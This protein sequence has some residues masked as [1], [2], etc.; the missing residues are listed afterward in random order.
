MLKSPP[1]KRITEEPIES[2]AALLES[3]PVSWAD[4]DPVASAKACSPIS[5]LC[6]PIE[7]DCNASIIESQCSSLRIM[8]QRSNVETRFAEGTRCAM[9]LEELLK[10]SI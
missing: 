9:H 4:R 5:H 6:P 8:I 10:R 7:A 1:G 2:H 3:I